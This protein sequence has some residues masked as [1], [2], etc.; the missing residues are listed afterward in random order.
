[1]DEAIVSLTVNIVSAY[2]AAN[3]VAAVQ[4][5]GLIR[6]VH[7]AALNRRATAGRTASAGACGRGAEIGLRRSPR[8]SRLRREL[9]DAQAA[10]LGRS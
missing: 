6:E 4:I 2:V 1:M 7:Q 10:S 5:S 9:Q 3:D 8:L